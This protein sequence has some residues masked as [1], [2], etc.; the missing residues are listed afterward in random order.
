ME[1]ISTTEP[2]CQFSMIERYSD[3]Y[4]GVR[5]KQIPTPGL[6]R[7][8]T[9]R[10]ILATKDN[11][12]TLSFFQRGMIPYNVILDNEPRIENGALVFE[13]DCGEVIQVIYLRF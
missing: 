7:L 13:I 8:L 10:G 5:S 3:K 11:Q 9:K 1:T 12:L 2:N 4:E 6:K